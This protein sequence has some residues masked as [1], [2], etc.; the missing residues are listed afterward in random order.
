MR[1][2]GRVEG[3]T[4]FWLVGGEVT[5]WCSRNPALS[6]KLPPSS[7]VGALVPQKNSDTALYIPGG[8]TRTLPQG[9]TI[10]S[11]LLLPSFCVPSLSWLAVVWICPLELR[12]SPGGWKKPISYK[13]ETNEE[14]E[15]REVNTERIFSWEGPTGLCFISGSGCQKKDPTIRPTS[16]CNRSSSRSN[17]ELSLFS[18]C[19][20]WWQMLR[21]FLVTLP[22]NWKTLTQAVPFSSSCQE[23][24]CCRGDRM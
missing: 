6:L 9:C 1:A 8:G 7:W 4:L 10:V 23:L 12:E 17:T 13:K 5:G 24:R 14:R 3:C 15:G 22:L 19:S 16:F 11:W 18:W 21:I 2:T 20:L